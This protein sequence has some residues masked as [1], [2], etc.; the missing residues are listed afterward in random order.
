MKCCKFFFTIFTLCI[1]SINSVAA[2][3]V[4]SGTVDALAY[5]GNNKL[6]VKLSSMNA[7]VFFCSPEFEWAPTGTTYKTGP[8]TCK[9]LYSTFLAAK[10]SGK[11]INSMYFDGDQVPATCSSWGNWKQAN[12]RYFSL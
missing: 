1:I 5:H 2:T 11:T 12:I 3:V 10:M 4:C 9:T 7:P 6:M 8:E